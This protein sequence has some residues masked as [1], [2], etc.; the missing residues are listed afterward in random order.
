MKHGLAALGF[1]LVTGPVFGKAVQCNSIQTRC[2]ADGLSFTIGDRVGFFNTDNELVARGEIVA[3]RGDRRAVDIEKRFGQITGEDRMALLHD[4]PRTFS[5][6]KAPGSYD[7]FKEP[8]KIIV[9]ASLGVAALNIGSGISGQDMS[10]FAQFHQMHGFK[11]IGRGSYLSG[12]GAAHRNLED[13]YEDVTVNLRG[14][15]LWGGGAYVLR[16]S[17]PLAFKTEA[18]LGLMN[19]SVTADGDSALIDDGEVDANI[20]SGNHFGGQVLV[21]AIVTI[22]NWH[23][24][25]DVSQTMISGLRPVTLGLGLSRDFE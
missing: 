16:E 14:F 19:A 17:R 4:G 24:H 8:S 25:F 21:G 18:T 11:V 23:G 12:V 22:S 7:T 13:G 15:S 2:V 1:L 10:V 9:G 5:A 6:N 3:M 20:R